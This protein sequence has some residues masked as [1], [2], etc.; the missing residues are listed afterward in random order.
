M[1]KSKVSIC[2]N[3]AVEHDHWAELHSDLLDEIIKH[4]DSYDSYV[5]LRAVCRQ[6]HYELPQNP[7]YIK[8]L[9]LVLPFNDEKETFRPFLNIGENKHYHLELPETRNTIF[10][11]SYYEWLIIIS[12]DGTLRMLNPFTGACVDLPSFSTFPNIIDYQ[13]DSFETCTITRPDGHSFS[14]SKI[15]MQKHQIKKLILSSQPE[16]DQDFM[17]LAIYGERCQLC[18]YRLGDNGWTSF[19]DFGKTLS[20]ATFHEGK[21]YVVNGRAQL[22]EFRFD[23]N[24][25]RIA[26]G[27]VPVAP[28]NYILYGDVDTI[29]V[30]GTPL[31]LLLVRRELEIEYNEIEDGF[32]YET[33]GFNVYKLSRDEEKM[34]WL[35]VNNLGD[36]ILLLGYNTSMCLLPQTITL[37]D[38]KGNRI[39]YTDDKYAYHFQQFFGGQ[40]V[41]V[42]DLE[43]GSFNELLP[44][45][46]QLFPAPVWLLK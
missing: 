1:S 27:I 43:D 16:H 6:W 46:E 39:Y 24:T 19:Q 22:Y 31:G 34:T 10:R 29:Y 5:R 3:M 44:D 9:W 30:V 18:Y 32:Y 28:L 25:R 41:G 20:D 23:T 33:C 2:N 40:D 42:F 7:K 35:E 45:I 13:S 17:A 26:G 8:K 4:V 36:Y 37:P 21:I 15:H 14:D 38:A 11:G 12:I